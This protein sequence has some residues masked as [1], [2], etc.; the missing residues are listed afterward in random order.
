MK[1]EADPET[2]EKKDFSNA[3]EEKDLDIHVIE[4]VG[5]DGQMG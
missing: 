4:T 5:S 2:K 3:E 1:N